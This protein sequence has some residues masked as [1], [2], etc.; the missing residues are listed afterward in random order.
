MLVQR[1]W[2]IR[3]ERGAWQNCTPW[4]RPNL[5]QKCVD[6]MSSAYG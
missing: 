4:K 6:F 1:Y 2:K 5:M 3:R